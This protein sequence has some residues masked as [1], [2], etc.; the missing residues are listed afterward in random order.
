MDLD[1]DPWICRSVLDYWYIQ[2]AH[3]DLD[4]DPAIFFSGF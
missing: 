2:I 1:S 3:L 4:P